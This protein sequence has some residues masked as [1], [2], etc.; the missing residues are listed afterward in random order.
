MEERACGNG[1]RQLKGV[2]VVWCVR[3]CVCVCVC[4]CVVVVVV[5]CVCVGRGG[6]CTGG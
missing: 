5:W 2:V 4:V 6:V 3:L 1:L